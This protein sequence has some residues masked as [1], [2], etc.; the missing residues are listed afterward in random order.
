MTTPKLSVAEVYNILDRHKLADQITNMWVSA[1]TNRRPWLDQ[2]KEL[3]DYIFATD[4][5]TTS[6]SALPWKNK[7]TIPKLCQIRDNLHANYMSALFPND[8]WL[9]WEGH[10]EDG[11][12]EE[13]R[14]AIQAYM[15]NKARMSNLATTV[16]QLLYDYIDYGNCFF[17]T[18]YVSESTED[19]ETGERIPG[20]VGPRLV[21]I[22]PLDIVHDPLAATFYDSWK[23][24]RS[25]KTLG[26]LAEEAAVNP[27]M[28]Y[29]NEI[30]ERVYKLRQNA[31]GFTA[32][33][34]DKAMA[35]E[36][37][38]FGSYSKYI[39]SDYVEILEFEG[40]TMQLHRNQIIT[41]VDRCWVVRQERI[42]SWLGKSSKGHVGWRLRPDNTYAMGPLD[43]LVGM[44][45]R[46]DHLENLKADAQDLSVLPPTFIS[47]QVEDFTWEPGAQIYGNEGAQVTELGKNLNGVIGAENSIDRLELRM[48]EMAGAPKQAMG[49]RTPGEK[50]AF[51]VQTLEMAASRIFQNKIQYFEVNGLEVALNNMLELSR[52]NLDGSDLIRVMDD[53]I[54]VA[55]FLTVTKEDITA[56]GKLRPVGA[57]HFAAQATLVQNLAGFLN[58]PAYSDPGVRVHLS[59]KKIAQLMPMLLGVDKFDLYQE[60][61]Q[62]TEN[63]ETQQLASQAQEDLMVTDA[64][65]IEAP[66]IPLEEV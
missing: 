59:G 57:R 28:G 51:E 7:T 1:N 16:S 6:N 5:T 58:S 54:G 49:I 27:E 21:R 63:L 22:S 8:E 10:S 61:V 39:E 17:D 60:N 9:K 48:E 43:N 62:V 40:D 41:I 37:D 52:R 65:P 20:Y 64:T 15:Q 45:Y 42:P 13:K 11:V 2:K 44:Q 30:L 26:E 34:L 29:N 66:D 38:G 12:T 4:T 53:D 23:I 47:G 3:R 24:V 50:T 36:V 46:I 33:D 19:P 56:S 55:T 31:Y 18:V 25:I 14:T 35:L 32:E